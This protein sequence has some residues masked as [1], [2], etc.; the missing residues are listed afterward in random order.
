MSIILNYSSVELIPPGTVFGA[1]WAAGG[2]NN[3]ATTSHKEQCEKG[4]GAIIYFWWR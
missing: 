1:V 2:F 4:Q 3:N